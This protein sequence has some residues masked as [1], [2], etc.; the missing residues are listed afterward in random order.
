MQDDAGDIDATRLIVPGLAG[1]YR[2][3]APFAYAFT[4]VT[5]GLM[6]LPSGVDKMFLGGQ[7]RIAAGNIAALGLEPRMAW[8][9]TVAGVEFFGAILMILG[10]FTR[11]VAFTLAV[12]LAVITFG[13]QIRSGYLWTNRGFELGL[14]MMLVCLAICFGGGGRWSLDRKIGKEF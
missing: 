4:R 11:P 8:A 14:L 1:L 3:G 9:W 13:L 7:A 6:F 12:Q 2:L 5:I 10:L